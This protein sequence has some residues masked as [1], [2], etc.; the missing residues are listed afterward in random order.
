M[1][2]NWRGWIHSWRELDRAD[3]A[4]L[5]Y[6]QAFVWYF[7]DCE[8]VVISRIAFAI[9]DTDAYRANRLLNRAR[10]KLYDVP[11]PGEIRRLFYAHHS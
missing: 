10:E 11:V 2:G 5:T 7:H 8:G 1:M 9:G 4:D 6:T 3:R